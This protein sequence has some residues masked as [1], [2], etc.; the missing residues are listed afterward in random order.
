[1]RSPRMGR[2]SSLTQ[3]AF[4]LGVSLP[5]TACM[6]A[7][8]GLQIA[9]WL[10]LLFSALGSMGPMSISRLPR[11]IDR[12]L[13]RQ[14]TLFHVVIAVMDQKSLLQLIV[15]SIENAAALQIRI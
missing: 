8:A 14:F 15:E 12:L 2:T 6:T 13:T 5:I 9:S 10:R 1:M 7:L 4:G 3:L 11:H